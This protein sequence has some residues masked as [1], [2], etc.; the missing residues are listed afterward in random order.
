MREHR[1]DLRG[2]EPERRPAVTELDG[3][4]ERARGAAADPHRDVLL[5]R[6]RVHEHPGELVEVARVLG[7]ASARARGAGAHRVVGARASVRERRTEQVEL[8]LE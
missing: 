5:L 2:A 6:A 4:A 7:F 1:F 8:L 3:T